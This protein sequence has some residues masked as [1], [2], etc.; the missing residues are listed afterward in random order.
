MNSKSELS[1]LQ[2]R[3]NKI[4]PIISPPTLSMKI[5]SDA[6]EIP[7]ELDQWTMPIVIESKP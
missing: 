7:V 3:L 4:A 2:A 6:K 1:R 5:V